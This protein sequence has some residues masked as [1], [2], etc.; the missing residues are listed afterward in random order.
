MKEIATPNNKNIPLKKDIF[1]WDIYNWSKALPIWEEIVQKVKPQ[2]TVAFGEREGGLSLWLALKGIN[3]I[4]TDFNVFPE[5]TPLKLHVKHKAESLIT[6]EKQDITNISY[7]DD[8]FDLVIFK[9]V[10]GA[11]GGF[12]LQKQ[13]I[14]ELFR[15]LKPDEVLLFAENARATNMHQYARKKFTNWG[16]RWYYPSHSEFKN[17]LQDFSKYELKSF[18]FFGTIGRTEKQRA[19]IGKIDTLINPIVPNS[20]KYINYGYAIK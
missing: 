16:E 20:W 18:G 5:A 10:I 2:K 15:I 19:F 14:N 3:V 12:E 6:Y 11:L 8:E 7:K 17:L 13:A 1:Q 4:C 9:S